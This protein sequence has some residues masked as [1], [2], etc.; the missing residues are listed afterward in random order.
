MFVSANGVS[1]HGLYDY[2]VL[3]FH[4]IDYVVFKSSN[5]T[6]IASSKVCVGHD[7]SADSHQHG[8][9]VR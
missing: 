7:F 9:H 6:A 3:I 1:G 2:V 4:F 8:F 5:F